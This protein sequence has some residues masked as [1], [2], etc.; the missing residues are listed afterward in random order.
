[1]YENSTVEEVCLD[2]A[3]TALNV[4]RRRIYDIVNVLESVGMVVRKAKNRYTWYGKSRM[5]S[6][7]A[8]LKMEAVANKL[9]TFKSPEVTPEK[10][11]SDANRAS[12]YVRTSHQK[13][14]ALCHG[15]EMLSRPLR[16][17]S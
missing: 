14:Q 17:K 8:A 2:T 10:S 13:P 1:M 12:P 6:T 4:E 15:P 3:S 16:S 5:E 11:V 7:L 9:G